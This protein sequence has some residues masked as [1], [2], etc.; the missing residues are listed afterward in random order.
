MLHSLCFGY[1]GRRASPWQ[2]GRFGVVEWRLLGRAIQ[3]LY[4]QFWAAWLTDQLG[5]PVLTEKRLIAQQ[6]SDIHHQNPRR[7]QRS[8]VDLIVAGRMIARRLRS[9]PRTCRPFTW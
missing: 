6:I 1:V 3:G 4:V 2:H 7:W 8:L 5:W 9:A